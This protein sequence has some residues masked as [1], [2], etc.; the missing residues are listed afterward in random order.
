VLGHN[1]IKTTLCYTPVAQPKSE[2]IQS[3][4]EAGI[5]AIVVFFNVAFLVKRRFYQF[6]LRKL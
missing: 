5:I 4:L 6:I 2:T 3:P 1:S